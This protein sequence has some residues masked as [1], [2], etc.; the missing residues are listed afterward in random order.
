[1]DTNQLA[2]ELLRS[3]ETIRWNGRAPT[4]IRFRSADALLIP[5]S[6]VWGGFAIFWESAVVAENAPILFRLWGIPFIC[7]AIYIIAGRFFV[8]AWLRSRTSYYVTD[9]AAYIVRS[10]P[11]GAM[12]RFSGSALDGVKIEDVSGTRAT[13]RLAS[14]N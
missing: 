13:I 11:L 10:A 1:M 7:V 5:F 3:G 12:C 8:D 14:P 4:G 9:R 2:P 6:L